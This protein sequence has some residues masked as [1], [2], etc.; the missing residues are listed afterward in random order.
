M[1]GIDRTG[2]GGKSLL[3]D[4]GSELR[5]GGRGEKRAKR[6][7]GMEKTS[8]NELVIGINAYQGT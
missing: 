4:P 2:G 1:Q 8:K 7:N 5:L 6:V 3:C